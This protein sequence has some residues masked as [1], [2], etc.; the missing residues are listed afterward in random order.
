MPLGLSLLPPRTVTDKLVLALAAVAS[1]GL[2]CISYGVFVERTWYRRRAYRLEILPPRAGPLTILHLSDL[3]F[4]AKDGAKARFMASL[5]EPDVVVLTGDII[6]EP[7]GV[8]RA[9]EA[10]RSV[11][12]RQ[13]SYFV[14]GSN[15]YF[16]PQPL[17]YFTYFRGPHTRRMARRNRT[18]DLVSQLE[19]D[20]WVHLK[21]RKTEFARDGLRF[22]VVGMD[23]PHIGRHD[24]RVALR[25]DGDAI[26][27]AVVHSPDPAPELAALGYP[28]I[29]SGHTHGGQVRL[30]F[31]GAL[32]T[33]SHIPNRLAMGLSRLG[34][35]LL[36]VS[37][38]LGTS[39]FAPFRFLCRPEATVLEL[40][41][42]R[43][44]GAA[45][46]QRSATGAEAAATA[47]S[48]TRS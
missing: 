44:E 17:N 9:V 20:G 39:K 38:G 42:A 7:G 47:R 29:L 43:S 30:P 19:R 18:G 3:H 23:D 36:H 6:G 48:N 4:L 34:P 25:N 33:N 21:N 16:A 11:R 35:S 46:G 24:L 27:L 37:P 41:P 8:E 12:G 5:G 14:L 10:L 13:A 22:E 15:D 26:G 45:N 31:V 32:V 1:A 28:L 40:V 2:G